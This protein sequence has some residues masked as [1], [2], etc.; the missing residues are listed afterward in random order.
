MCLSEISAPIFQNCPEGEVI[1]LILPQSQ[2]YA[3]LNLR[4]NA[5]DFLGQNIPIQGSHD[6]PPGAMFRWQGI[7]KNGYQYL[8][9]L[10]TDDWGQQV[11]CSF[12]VLV[13]DHEPPQFKK[14]PDDV[15]MITA[16][17]ATRVYWQEPEATDNVGLGQLVAPPRGPGSHF[18][19]GSWPISYR[20]FDKQGNIAW[21]NFTVHVDKIRM[22]T[23]AF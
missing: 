9:Y 11:W 23:N 16:R 14:C 7:G 15:H 4:L 13:L 3:F 5:H 21:C 10:A 17:S 18:D 6:I 12:I 1:N 22:L 8:R 19:I 20:V 2:P